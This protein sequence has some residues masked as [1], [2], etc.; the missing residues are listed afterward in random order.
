MKYK[1][2]PL[3][4]III[5]VYS[6]MQNKN[7][8]TEITSIVKDSII[9]QKKIAP[10]FKII[11]SQNYKYILKVPVNSKEVKLEDPDI[12]INLMLNN[13]ATLTIKVIEPNNEL[14]QENS[15]NYT[16]N[17]F[18]NYKIDGFDIHEI[19][20]DDAILIYYM[21][22]RKSTKGVKTTIINNKKKF[23]LI[24]ETNNTNFN[25]YKKI[26][27]DIFL[28][29]KF[30]TPEIPTNYNPAFLSF[31][32]GMPHDEFIKCLEN[33]YNEGN[34]TKIVDSERIKYVFEIPT[35]QGAIGFNVISNKNDV[36]LFY[37]TNLSIKIEN[38]RNPF[39][40][41]NDLKLNFKY[42]E[43]KIKKLLKE[44]ILVQYKIASDIKSILSS[45]YSLC[46]TIIPP[47]LRTVD[48]SNYKNSVFES[49]TLF[50]ILSIGINEDEDLSI[51]LFDKLQHIEENSL[52]ET[53][54]IEKWN[55]GQIKYFTKDCGS[56]KILI[57]YVPK[58]I[59][60]YYERETKLMN[61]RK[62]KEDSLLKLKNIRNIDK[63]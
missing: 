17:E 29:I 63:L 50:I 14:N 45:K 18:L 16:F 31:Y 4:I 7:E 54:F 28:S 23:E 13:E 39:R 26:F 6:C 32:P 9:S 44:S 11:E 10:K 5:T 2:A 41:P 40:D 61:L 12:D 52:D 3:L 36:Q 37:K 62:H 59:W 47:D 15:S 55:S 46:N 53:D 58:F 25:R 38:T 60:N 20:G 30:E 42:D 56:F 8:S 24:A 48:Y 35:S 34:L 19:N 51:T 49:E 22:H 1:I 27:L 43:Q 33:E 21:N 57:R